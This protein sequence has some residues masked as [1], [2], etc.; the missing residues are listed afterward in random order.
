MRLSLGG[1]VIPGAVSSSSGSPLPSGR[2]PNSTL[3]EAVA[4]TTWPKN[5]Q[6]DQGLDNVDEEFND[7]WRQSEPRRKVSIRWRTCCRG[8]TAAAND[9]DMIPFFSSFTGINVIISTTPGCLTPSVWYDASHW[10][11]SVTGLLNRFWRRLWS[12]TTS[13]KK[14]GRRVLFLERGIQMFIC[15]V[16]VHLQ[17][18]EFGVNGYAGELPKWFMKGVDFPGKTAP[19]KVEMGI[20]GEDLPVLFWAAL[21]WI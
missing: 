10:S 9:G 21:E 14:L 15:Q 12:I 7:L 18:G 13:I 19:R 11:A 16:V 17:L 2:P 5:A 20:G 1:A 8:N 3:I 4:T 6:R